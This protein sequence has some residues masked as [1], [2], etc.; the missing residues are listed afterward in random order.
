[1]NICNQ[2]CLF[3]N[4]LTTHFIVQLSNF[5]YLNFENKEIETEDVFTNN[6]EEMQL[7]I[8]SNKCSCTYTYIFKTIVTVLIF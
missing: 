3:F 5:Q 7:C 6:C 2:K 4:E 8:K 1:M